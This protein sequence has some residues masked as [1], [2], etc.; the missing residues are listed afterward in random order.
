MVG[1]VA[2]WG[3]P[4]R[5]RGGRRVRGEYRACVGRVGVRR[6]GVY[7][8][9]IG[10]GRDGG[11]QGGSW[12]TC[13]DSVSSLCLSTPLL[14]PA[15]GL[16]AQWFG[17]QELRRTRE[18]QQHNQ[19]AMLSGRATHDSCSTTASLALATMN[20][21]QAQASAGATALPSYWLPTCSADDRA[22]LTQLTG[23]VSSQKSATYGIATS[24][25]TE[26]QS[27]VGLLADQLEAR[28]AYDASYLINKTQT[29][30]ELH[31][32]IQ[33]VA[34]EYS[35]SIDLRLQSLNMSELL[36]CAT[37]TPTAGACPHGDSAR[38]LVQRAQDR[39][40]DQY[41]QA[42]VA[43]RNTAERFEGYAL[44]AEE[45]LAAA[46]S[47][48][49]SIAN[50]CDSNLPEM[51]GFSGLGY[52]IPDL[53]V[54]YTAPATSLPALDLPAGPDGIGE[55]V[56]AAVVQFQQS[57]AEMRENANTDTSALR[58]R[59]ADAVPAGPGDYH[60]PEVDAFAVKASHQAKSDHFEQEMAES[61]DE[62]DQTRDT[63]NQSSFGPIFG[64]N[65]TRDAIN[66]AR[67]TS[68]F[69]YRDLTDLG[70]DFDW[71]TS[72]LSQIAL[73]LQVLDTILRSLRTV[74]IFSRF[75]GRSALPVPPIDMETDADAK[76]RGSPTFNAMQRLALLMTNPILVST[77]VVLYFYV[78]GAIAF[79]VYRPF[80]DSYTIGCTATRLNEFGQVE[81]VGEGTTITRNVY[82]VAYNYAA[83][84]GNKDRLL[85]ID[86]YDSAR[87][88]YCAQYGSQSL[89]E[90][91][92]V[93]DDLNR[94]VS[95]H[96]RNREMVML[97]RTCYDVDTID[98]SFDAT[99]TPL[100]DENGGTYPKLSVTLGSEA[101]AND[102]DTQL[103]N[104]TLQDGVFNC[105]AL[106]ECDMQCN[107]LSDREGRD[108]SALI[109][110]T[111]SACCTF[112]WYIHAFILRTIFT[113][114]IYLTVNFS[115][116]VFLGGLVRVIWQKLNTGFFSYHATCARNGEHT[117]EKRDLEDKVESM[118]G[119]IGVKGVLFMVAAFAIQLPWIFILQSFVRD[120]IYADTGTTS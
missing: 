55:S 54:A 94:V 120:L 82:S 13:R 15:R 32:S 28:A 34:L 97:M 38:E 9:G 87:G 105:D 42:E 112:E 106:P 78:I 65:F 41:A 74:Q 84:A 14:A 19:E 102:C 30:L 33:S 116:V 52:S 75:W 3:A 66:A 79:S 99:V 107:D 86:A 100:T 68:W 40:A 43:Y 20:A 37:L 44:T 56:D 57:V 85:G 45:K 96:S 111:R 115:R 24:Y 39:L 103:S 90:Q 48:L 51:G 26:S 110:F 71:L 95:A 22:R 70:V 25:S 73:L 81:A 117:Y 118:L 93:E 101:Q 91:R 47:T 2:R 7:R 29:S 4:K 72:K 109:W 63:A 88:R 21:W 76:A 27:T 92:R 12:C 11:W 67:D 114:I 77:V 53:G 36:A 31:A 10:V 23:D 17:S 104:A 49:T 5:V 6:V 18:A 58:K 80:Y 61:L 8:H 16:T 50:W 108:N 69:N 98:A 46:S 89:D 62:F 35:T 119:W 64:S 60:P 83:S 113:I 1:A 59:I